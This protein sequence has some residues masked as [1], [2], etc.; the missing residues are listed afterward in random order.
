V[1][2]PQTRDGAAKRTADAAV[3]FAAHAAHRAPSKPMWGS[4]SLLDLLPREVDLGDTI[5][6]LGPGSR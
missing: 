6:S 2:N 4:Y 1:L 5:K 3:S